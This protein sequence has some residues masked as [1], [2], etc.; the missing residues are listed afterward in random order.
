MPYG[1]DTVIIS[2]FYCVDRTS[3]N[4]CVLVDTRNRKKNLDE[5]RRIEKCGR[6]KERPI[7]RSGRFK[8]EMIMVDMV[9]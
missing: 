6:R 8:A 7:P 2:G 3:L 9:K 4:I 5:S 1:Y